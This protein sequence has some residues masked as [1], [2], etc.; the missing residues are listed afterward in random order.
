MFKHEINIRVRYGETDQMG[1]V[2]YGNYALYYEVARVEALRSLGCSYQQLEQSGIFMPVSTLNIKFLLPARYD[3]ELLVT[4]RIAELPTSR[5]TF[6]YEIYGA[7]G[8]LL[9]EAETSL[10]FISATT[11]KPIRVPNNLFLAL[12][13]FF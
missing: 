6:L 9:N 8:V 13:P 3:E 11:H 12:K 2:Y 10:A 5:I 7:T 1:F 4:T